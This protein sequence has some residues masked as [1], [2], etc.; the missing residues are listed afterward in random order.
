MSILK[1]E[2]QQHYQL[3]TETYYLILLKEKILLKTKILLKKSYQF[4]ILHY[5]YYYYYY[6]LILFN[7]GSL[8]EVHLFFK[9]P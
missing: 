9:G 2:T 7:H 1:Q 5:Y 8:S 6:F 3:R 4:E